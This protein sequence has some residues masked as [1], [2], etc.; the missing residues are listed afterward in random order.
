MG[1]QHFGGY[2]DTGPAGP[3]TPPL[4][5]V[6]EILAVRWLGTKLMQINYQRDYTTNDESYPG[7][8]LGT[9][10]KSVQC[11][12]LKLIIVLEGW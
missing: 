10:T 7:G 12:P 8:L 6:I 1:I 2:C 9:T 4:Y 3:A 5:K 11:V